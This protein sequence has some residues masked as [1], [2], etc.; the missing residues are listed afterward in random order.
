MTSF[1]ALSYRAKYRE[2]ADKHKLVIVEFVP[3]LKGKNIIVFVPETS[4]V[5]E[6]YSAT[7]PSLSDVVAEIEKVMNLKVKLPEPLVELPPRFSMGK[8]G[9]TVF[10]FKSEAVKEAISMIKNLEKFVSDEKEL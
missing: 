5:G 7:V 1:G 2:E 6:G 4:G 8:E 3:K 9:L 10:F